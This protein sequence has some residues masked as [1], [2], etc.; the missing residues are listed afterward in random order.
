M[1]TIQKV[2]MIAGALY[3]IFSIVA[4]LTPSK[5]DDKIL[6]KIGSLFDKLG[7]N[8]RLVFDKKPKKR[9]KKR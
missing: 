5:K 4:T 3:V 8:P 2:L 7:F 9:G 1:D 6:N